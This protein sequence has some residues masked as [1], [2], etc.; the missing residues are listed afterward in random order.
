MQDFVD[1]ITAGRQPAS[2]LQLACDVV[3]VIYSAY[4]SAAENRR[5]QLGLSLQATS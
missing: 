1:A 2:G 4:V 3:E 5:V